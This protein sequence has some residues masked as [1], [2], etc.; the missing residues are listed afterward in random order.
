MNFLGRVLICA[1]ICLIGSCLTTLPIIILFGITNDYIVPLRL[2]SFEI[3]FIFCYLF[4]YSFGYSINI[5]H[6]QD[7]ITNRK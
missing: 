7:E 6:E 5:I 4:V 3:R 1:I 2:S